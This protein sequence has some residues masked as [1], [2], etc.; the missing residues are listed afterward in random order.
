MNTVR[1]TEFDYG[2]LDQISRAANMLL[3]DRTGR[4]ITQRTQDGFVQMTDGSWRATG[5]EVHAIMGLGVGLATSKN[6]TVQ[7]IGL[8]LLLVIGLAWFAGASARN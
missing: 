8:F 2:G 7:Y 6:R 5:F 1:R 4:T 3:G